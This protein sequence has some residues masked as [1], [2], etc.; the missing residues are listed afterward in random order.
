MPRRTPFKT[1][2]NTTVDKPLKE[3]LALQ[4]D[5]K[6]KATMLANWEV[7]GDEGPLP[8]PSRGSWL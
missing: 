3:F 2:A 4:S 8:F 1:A 6:K 7:E 5:V